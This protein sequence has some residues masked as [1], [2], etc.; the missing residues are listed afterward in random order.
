M[1]KIHI[2]LIAC[3]LIFFSKNATAQSKYFAG[4]H[5]GGHVFESNRNIGDTF[6][7][8]LVIGYDFNEKI[9]AAVRMYTGK[10]KVKYA[11]D[12]LTC[13]TDSIRGELYHADLYYR[14]FTIQNIK[15]Y[16]TGGIGKLNVKHSKS[17][18]LY[19][20]S[21]DQGVLFNYGAGLEFFIQDVSLMADIRHFMSTGDFRN[22]LVV[23]T[24]LVFRFPAG[25]KSIKESLKSVK[26]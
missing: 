1:K 23:T 4:I 9:S 13:T 18:D 12:N 5:T 15:P 14:V 7:S 19:H 22:E 26:Y 24:G 3:L 11:R 16:I 20:D 25:I 2:S 21:F 8:G 6:L 17:E 10:Y